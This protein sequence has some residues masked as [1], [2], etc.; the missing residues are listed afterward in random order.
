MRAFLKLIRIENLLFI[1]FI[2]FLIR[3]ALFI[4]FGIE[5]AL[6]TFQFVLLVLATVFLAA[7]GYII[8]DIQDIVADTIN[9]P[10]KVKATQNITEKMSYNYFIVF[11]VLAVGIGFYLANYIDKPAL[12]AFFIAISALLFIY[13][14]FL[15]YIL[16]V[17]NLVVAVLAALVLISLG[18][19]DLMPAIT[20][21]NQ[22]A[23]RVI[24]SVILD[25]ALFALLLTFLR[26]IV[27]DIEDIDGDQNAGI[28]TLPIVLGSERTAKIA[29]IFG[30]FTVVAVVFYVYNYL[31]KYN[32][33]ILY[34]LLL[35]IAPLVFFCVKIL[36]VKKKKEFGFLSTLLKI[37]MFLGMLS[38]A[39][40]PFLLGRSS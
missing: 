18:I 15:K 1:I 10:K 22:P 4:P 31:Y 33:A 30:A 9:R 37:I 40:L 8:N 35:V 38:M 28:K 11:N 39:L 7:G 24:F 13:S 34:F 5:T 3:Y 21:S 12:V 6:P 16:I 23:M 29:F 27:K 17:K 19:F 36:S 20:E 14:S 2:Q 32:I 26:E 25:Y